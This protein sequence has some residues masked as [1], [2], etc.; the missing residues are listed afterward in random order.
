MVEFS[1]QVS[2]RLGARCRRVIAG[3]MPAECHAA[4]AVRDHWSVSCVLRGPCQSSMTAAQ[5]DSFSEWQYGSAVP[6]SRRGLNPDQHATSKCDSRRLMIVSMAG[7]G[8]VSPEDRTRGPLCMG[9]AR[10]VRANTNTP[11]EPFPGGGG[12]GQ[13]RDVQR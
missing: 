6:G 1:L 12:A 13:P 8:G 10:W 4:A 11:A 3:E 2:V 9:G 7:G 5:S